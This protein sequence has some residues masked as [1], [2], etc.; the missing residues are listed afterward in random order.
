MK[1]EDRAINWDLDSTQQVINK[2]N[3]ADTNPGVRAHLNG[4]SVLLFG[5][6]PEPELR[7]N[8][9]DL[10]AIHDSGV[11]IATRDGA[12]WIRQLKGRDAQVLQALLSSLLNKV[13]PRA[14]NDVRV[15]HRHQLREPL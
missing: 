1:Q 4:Y 10:L 6:R 8:P 2:I 13:Q 14:G 7:G 9:G 15:H 5:A 3:A 12:V 11:C